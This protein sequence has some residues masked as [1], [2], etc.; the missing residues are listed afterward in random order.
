MTLA[1]QADVMNKLR[2]R[3]TNY[4][5]DN[6]DSDDNDLEANEDN[7]YRDNHYNHVNH[8][9]VEVDVDIHHASN[10]PVYN[11]IQNHG[12]L[13]NNSYMMRGDTTQ[14]RHVADIFGLNR[15]T[16][17]V[18][19]KNISSGPLNE[20][21]EN[22]ANWNNIY[23]HNEDIYGSTS[24]AEVRPAIAQILQSTKNIYLQ[25][26][27]ANNNDDDIDVTSFSNAIPSSKI[28][29]N[30]YSNYNRRKAEAQITAADL[31]SSSVP[32]SQSMINNNIDSAL[33][34]EAK[35]LANKYNADVKRIQVI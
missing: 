22:E 6:V 24:N 4:N 9:D 7:A 25:S 27:N 34:E 17:I 3:R 10:S 14:R 12:R 29:K 15:R 32:L 13:K 5:A 8:D 31:Q 20:N 19:D 11:R 1:L 30:R 2:L 23:S 28:T 21:I 33:F 16:S 26:D 18:D 35:L